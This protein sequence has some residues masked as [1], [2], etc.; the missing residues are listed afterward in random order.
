[1]ASERPGEPGN[2]SRFFSRLFELLDKHRHG[3]EPEDYDPEAVRR[4]MGRLSWIFGPGRY[5]RISHR[6]WENVP[7]APALVVANHSGGTCIPDAW[8]LLYCWYATFGVRRPL[9]PLG[10]EMVFILR[11][12]ARSFAKGGALRASPQMALRVLRDHRRDVLVMPGGDVETWRPWRDR[13]ELRWGARRGY[14]RIALE[15]GVPVVPI[16]CSGAHSTLFVLSDGRRLGRKL[17]IYRLARSD[18]FPIHL[19]LPWGLGIG[20][21]PHLPL[22]TRLHYL[23]GEPVYPPAEAVAGTRPGKRLVLEFDARVRRAMQE[24]LNRLRG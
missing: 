9:H 12:L 24:L 23:V 6:G 1:M 16:A 17:G 2:R 22:P 21:L 8:G 13:Y 7:R 19:S 3:L 15:A 18:I 4:M 11:D 14:A 10:H 5:F 20:P